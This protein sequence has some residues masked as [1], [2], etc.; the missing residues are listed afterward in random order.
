MD[1]VGIQ[2][3]DVVLFT[4]TQ[5]THGSKYIMKRYTL[6]RV[7][8]VHGVFTLLRGVDKKLYTVYTKDCVKI[9]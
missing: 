1:D 4:G 7:C 2:Q 8:D 6:G 3:G 9:G 5:A